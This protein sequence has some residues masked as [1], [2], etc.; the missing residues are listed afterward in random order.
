VV[1][2]VDNNVNLNAEKI[3]FNILDNTIV[4]ANQWRL[5][6]STRSNEYT[7][8]IQNEG[9]LP[10]FIPWEIIN[11]KEFLQTLKMFSHLSSSIPPK[12]SFD[13]N[14]NL[15]IKYRDEFYNIDNGIIKVKLIN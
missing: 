5:K 14:Y 3:I 15:E 10:S 2:I 7:N 13:L 12:F 11:D 8:V 9:A 4:N 6:L 1:K